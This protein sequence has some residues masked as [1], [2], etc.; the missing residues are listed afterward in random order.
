[1]SAGVIAAVQ[2]MITRV[3]TIAAGMP[4]SD[5]Y[6]SMRSTLLD[7]AAAMQS[8][9]DMIVAS[10]VPEEKIDTQIL[11]SLEG[12]TTTIAGLVASFSSLKQLDE[13]AYTQLN[14]SVDAVIA[15]IVARDPAPRR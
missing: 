2:A 13:T 1:M 5:V 7:C 6:D 8:A 4:S 3:G 14:D 15:A 10:G 12:M 11:D 9:L